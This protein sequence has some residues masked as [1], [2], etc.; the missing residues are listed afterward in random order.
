MTRSEEAAL[1]RVC[2][3]AR[4]L[5]VPELDRA[6]LEAKIRARAER[7]SVDSGIVPRRRNWFTDYRM[8]VGSTAIAAA[9]MIG[10]VVTQSW[11]STPAVTKTDGRGVLIHQPGIDGERLA[12]GQTVEARAQDLTIQHRGIVT[13]RLAAPSRARIVE[14]GERITVALEQGRVDAE[15]VPQSRSEVFAVEIEHVRVA[16]HGT[17]FTVERRGDA[18][19]V[20]VSEGSVRLGTRDQRGNT[21]GEILQAPMRKN[22]DVRTSTMDPP[23]P[24]ASAS[25][26]RPRARHGAKPD[27]AAGSAA[28]P[29]RGSAPIV[30]SNLP[31][32][33][34][35]AEVEH[36]WELINR[37]VS[38]CFSE[39]PGGDPNVRV[40]FSTRIGV[41]VSPDGS[42]TISNFEPPLAE[43]LHQCIVQQ[44][45]TLRTAPSRSG[46]FVRREKM[47]M[48]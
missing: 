39:Q 37:E 45:A 22:L 33:P 18:A 30:D 12:L 9:A 20:I 13:W 36:L 24:A 25:P 10:L 29:S 38:L 11:R 34:S 43:P 2:Q 3:Q 19:E 17:V 42:V 31:E 5:P 47:L 16:V 26:P 1:A 8:Y 46:T 23:L 28:S 41:L 15:V 32:A 40:S 48:R 35:P 6:A 21:Q 7:T 27:S 14:Q 4:D 44:I